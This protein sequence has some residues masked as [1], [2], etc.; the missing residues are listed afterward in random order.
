MERLLAELKVHREELMTE[1]KVKH[2]KLKAKMEAWQA[3]IEACREATVC[4]QK[5]RGHN[6]CRQGTNEGKTAWKI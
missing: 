6:R 2:E 3:E 4:L 5:T 1:M